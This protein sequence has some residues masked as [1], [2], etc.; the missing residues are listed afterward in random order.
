[1]SRLSTV[2]LRYQVRNSREDTIF[3]SGNDEP[4]GVIPSQLT[5]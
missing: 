4:L 3:R 2:E 5:K 1:M